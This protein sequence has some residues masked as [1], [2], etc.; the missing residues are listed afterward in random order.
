MAITF[1][2]PAT[3]SVASAGPPVAP[4][5]ANPADDAA[6]SQ[7]GRLLVDLFRYLEQ[8]AVEH[9][10]LL[11]AIAGLREAVAEY[12][13]STPAATLDGVRRVVALINQARFVDAALPEP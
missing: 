8:H 9:P 3:V 10:A 11:S 4:A 2:K 7:A 5:A 12:R 1:T 6:R 13:S